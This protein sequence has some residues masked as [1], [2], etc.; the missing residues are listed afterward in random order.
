M[1]PIVLL[2]LGLL[3]LASTLA[4]WRGGLWERTVSGLLVA[5]FGVTALASFDYVSP[6]WTAIFVDCVVFLVL[7]YACLRSRRRWI[8]F[9]AAFQF[10]VLATH[11]VFV[12]NDNLMQWAYVSAYYIWN[13]SLI[14]SLCLGT[15]LEG[16]QRLLSSDERRDQ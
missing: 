9:A 1:S 8:I 12:N 2:N 6:P 4:L 11:Y 10:L 14:I 3:G 5:A 16:R 15:I 7:L 13:I